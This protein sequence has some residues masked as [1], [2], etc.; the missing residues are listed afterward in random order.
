MHVS[1][2]TGGTQNPLDQPVHAFE[3]DIRLTVFG[4]GGY[5]HGPGIGAYRTFVNHEAAGERPGS[6]K[7]FSQALEGHGYDKKHERTGWYFHGLKL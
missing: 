4:P 7:A 1:N 6:Q 5:E 3:C 2:L